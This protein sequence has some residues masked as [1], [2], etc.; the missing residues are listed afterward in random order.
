[1]S[2]C[3][4]E[5]QYD[6][7]PKSLETLARE[8]SDLRGHVLG[9]LSNIYVQALQLGYVVKDIQIN[10]DGTTEALDKLRLDSVWPVLGAD[11]TIEPNHLTVAVPA[12][13]DPMALARFRG[14]WDMKRGAKHGEII[15]G[16]GARPYALRASERS[17][18]MRGQLELLAEHAERL[19]VDGEEQA[20]VG[21]LETVTRTELEQSLDI[22]ENYYQAFL[23]DYK[24]VPYRPNNV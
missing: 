7:V 16:R 22:L 20:F 11:H 2:S 4:E 10:P 17:A 5:Y 18:E 12:A 24:L 23:G 9:L 14:E 19:S 1:M 21:D 3:P 6:N 13:Q 15:D 8:E